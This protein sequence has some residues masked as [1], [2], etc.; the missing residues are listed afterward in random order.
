LLTPDCFD[1]P[2][3]RRQHCTKHLPPITSLSGFERARGP[4]ENPE[5]RDAEIR[6]GRS[7]PVDD[8]PRRPDFGPV[9]VIDA[10]RVR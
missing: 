10:R 4:A 7:C 9:A 3:E 1:V 2:L 5:R 6:C 8:D